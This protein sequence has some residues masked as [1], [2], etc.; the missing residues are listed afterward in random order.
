MLL[1]KLRDYA[2]RLD[3]PPRLYSS[4]P[5]R[6]IIDLDREGKP[7]SR[8]LIDTADPASSAARRGVRRLTPSV[9]RSV[10]I[11]PFLLTDKSDYALG[12][13]REGGK[14][15]RVAQCHGAFVDLAERCAEATNEPA[16]NA[17]VAFLRRGPL[18][19]IALDDRF[20]PGGMIAFRVDGVIPTDLAP[21]QAFWAD[22]NDAG[23]GSA[24]S[25][26]CITCG[27]LRPALERLELKVK[28]VPGGQTAGTS[29]ISFNAD[30]F[31]SYGLKASLNAPTCSDCGERFT[32]AVN[33]L[34]AGPQSCVRLQNI[35][36]IFWTKEPE[37]DLPFA[38]LLNEAS[39]QEV[40][41]LYESVFFGKRG[42]LSVQENRFYATA[43]SGSGGRAVVREWIDTTVGEAKQHLARWFQM[44][45]VI[46]VTKL[47]PEIG[48][49]L[50]LRQLAYAT[51]RTGD[52]NNP[53]PA[54]VS[55]EL[56]R[57]ALTGAPLPSDLL[58]QAARRCRAEQS[59]TRPRA[60]LIKMVLLSQRRDFDPKEDNMVELDQ[61]NHDPAY[62]CGRLLAVLE[63][64]QRAAL[65]G[66][67]ATIVDRFY[68]TASS[69]PAS[70]FGRLMRG[71]QPHL[72]RLERDRRGAFVAI[73]RR[74]EEVQ[75][76]LQ[77]FPKTLTL[78]QQGLF[79]LG[80]YHER[81]RR[82]TKAED[83]DIEEPAG[84]EQ[85]EE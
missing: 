55:R 34:L 36:Y 12:H 58:Y 14:P 28:G 50:P 73:Q 59:V 61:A 29:I 25:M 22:E 24:P 18:T 57:T 83:G 64:A 77:G 4:L 82:W 66:I 40:K 62:L 84:G 19:Q 32:N 70:V 6:Y 53:A 60:A 79:A 2:G 9:Q 35:A 16:V 30:A 51:V 81:A 68:G 1:G 78:E 43:L 65:P 75:S 31:E 3:L 47:G 20:D 80:Y 42:A 71:V 41:A 10:G 74:L 85:E 23:H 7:L 52:R 11:K 33:H 27:A 45:R 26:Q 37:S 48:Q 17:V 56:L 38:P 21:V 5:V 44:Q 72:G 13:V 67:N 15:D 49:P 76:H 63:Q 69:A 8:E 39:P 46:H 54:N